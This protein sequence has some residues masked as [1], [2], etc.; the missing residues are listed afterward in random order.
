MPKTT[1]TTTANALPT[2]CTNSMHLAAAQGLARRRSAEPACTLKAMAAITPR[3]P[4]KPRFLRIGQ[5]KSIS[6]ST[7]TSGALRFG[8][9]FLPMPNSA[10]AGLAS[11]DRQRAAGERH[12]EPMHIELGTCKP[13]RHS[14]GSIRTA[15]QCTGERQTSSIAIPA[16]SQAFQKV[17]TTIRAPASARCLKKANSTTPGMLLQVPDRRVDLCGPRSACASRKCD[18]WAWLRGCCRAHLP[19]QK[20]LMAGCIGLTIKSFF[21]KLEHC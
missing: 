3:T 6:L 16:S 21:N 2:V 17:V 20:F 14:A 15:A 13:C 12:N 1:P 7:F 9:G 18:A 10:W 4:L 8:F 19:F 11:S 5:L